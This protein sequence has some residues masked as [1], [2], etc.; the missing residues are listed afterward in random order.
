MSIGRNP[1][2]W[3]AVEKETAMRDKTNGRL[4]GDNMFL[5]YGKEVSY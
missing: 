3:M 5:C 1:Q 4:F 2:K